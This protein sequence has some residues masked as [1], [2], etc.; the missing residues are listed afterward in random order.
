M[1]GFLNQAIKKAYALGQ[2][3]MLERVREII[4]GEMNKTVHFNQVEFLACDTLACGILK[5]L[6]NL[7]K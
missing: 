3:D 6:Y 1:Q 2:Q 4:K 5:A 7:T